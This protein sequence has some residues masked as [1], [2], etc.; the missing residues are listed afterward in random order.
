MKVLQLCSFS[1]LFG[2][3]RCFIECP[4]VRDAS[5]GY[6]QSWKSVS[7]THSTDWVL[8]AGHSLNISILGHPLIPKLHISPDCAKLSSSLCSERL[9]FKYS[10]LCLARNDGSIFVSDTVSSGLSLCLWRHCHIG[11]KTLPQWRHGGTLYEL[12]C[13]LSPFCSTLFTLSG[14]WE[15]SPSQW[16]ALTG[17]AEVSL[18]T[19]LWPSLTFVSK[20]VF[21]YCF[22]FWMLQGSAP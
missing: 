10:S 11:L 13:S 1:K 2:Y 20:Q 22:S 8:K 18:L 21:I 16:W 7:N 19:L 12:V 15:V 3:W 9:I 5:F 14:L 4:I 17:F 6:L